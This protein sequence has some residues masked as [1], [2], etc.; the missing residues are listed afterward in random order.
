MLVKAPR[1]YLR[2]AVAVLTLCGLVSCGTE[3]T[4][5]DDGGGAGQGGGEQEVSRVDVTPS[6]QTILGA[7]STHQF[8]ATA[9]DASGSAVS[10]ATISW[11]S[12]STGVATITSGG[13]AT[14]TGIGTTTITASSSGISGTASLSVQEAPAQFSVF[15]FSLAQGHYWD[16]FWSYEYNS[17]SGAPA[18]ESG[19]AP[20]QQ[21]A[22]NTHTV[23]GGH[24]RITLGAPQ[25][26]GG[27]TSYQLVVTGD[28]DDGE[29]DYTP[30]WTHLAVDGN[31]V[32]GSTD[33]TTLEVIFDAKNGSWTG[34]GFWAVYGSDVQVA[35]SSAS[36]ENEFIETAALGVGRS[37]G[38]DFCETIAGIQICSNDQ[39]WTLRETE[40][41]KSGIGPIGYYS[42]ASY[43]F[44][45]GGFYDS[46]THIRHVGLVASSLPGADGIVPAVPPWSEGATM[47]QARTN[48]STAVVDGKIY[49]MGGNNQTNAGS[50][51]LSSVDMYDP[52][53]NSWTSRASMPGVRAGHT[54][55]VVDG[56]IYVVGGESVM[57]TTKHSTV[58]EYDPVNNFWDTKASTPQ[59]MSDHSAVAYDGYV[60][61][62][63]GT[64]NNAYAY[65][66]AADTWWQGTSS[67]ARYENHATVRVGT[68]I[69]L[70][71][72]DFD[73]WSA[74]VGAYLDYAH[75][76]LEFDLTESYGSTNAWA[77]R[78]AMPTD[79][80][81]LTAVVL[82][83]Q[84]YAI[85]GMN[86]DGARRAVE[87]YDPVTNSWTEGFPLLTALRDHTAAAVD[88]KVY[89]MGGRETWNSLAS[90]YIYD[91][92]I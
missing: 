74:W 59:T 5:I 32:L 65:E 16:F 88:G 38:Q 4:G 86:S 90:V 13:L 54:S 21:P 30:R 85:G 43:A 80:N 72:G 24:F 47:P 6:T 51:M 20:Q 81:R 46:F 68:S 40:Y 62:F 79:R 73:A 25:D 10:G 64:N 34:G 11:S 83:D 23:T 2:I 77:Y 9:R 69:F 48:H 52:A 60:W 29:F 8:S 56:K 89:V 28:V 91:P 82:N 15:D 35:A 87:I 70:L 39:A 71:G 55:T 17:V 44:S 66:V 31:Q 26:I 67:S 92:G 36:L 42:Y 33:G 57:Y 58:W 78:A 1:T 84:V 37:S 41:F 27:V 53:L 18:W 75:T 3:P 45:G 50:T 7:G 14:A 63:P 12:S 19:S 76:C 22:A 49:V 61:V